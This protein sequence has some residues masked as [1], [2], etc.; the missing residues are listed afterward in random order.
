MI[1]L[2][3]GSVTP[4]LTWGGSSGRTVLPLSTTANRNSFQALRNTNTIVT[5]IPP[6]TCGM[7]MRH[8]VFIRL[9]P[10]R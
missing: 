6:R 3:P 9:A 2:E 10:S 4:V 8:S 7:M 1:V 5:A